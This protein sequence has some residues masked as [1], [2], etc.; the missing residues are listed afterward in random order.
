MP[1]IHVVVGLG[2][3]STPI[4]SRQ[5]FVCKWFQGKKDFLAETIWPKSM[6]KVD[7]VNTFLHIPLGNSIGLGSKLLL[8]P[9]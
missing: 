5:S 4:S 8:A 7:T 6:V 1:L 3:S 9:V 2:Q